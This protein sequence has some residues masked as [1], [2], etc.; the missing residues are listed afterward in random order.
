MGFFGFPWRIAFY[1]IYT[2]RCQRQ[3]LRHLKK[4]QLIGSHFAYTDWLVEE[5]M[6][7]WG[8]QFS[9]LIK[10][11][12]WH[13]TMLHCLKTWDGNTLPG[14]ILDCVIWNK[15]VFKSNFYNGLPA[16]LF[17]IWH[18][19]LRPVYQAVE[20]ASFK[21]SSIVHYNMSL[22]CSNLLHDS[23]SEILQ[24]RRI[25][26]LNLLIGDSFASQNLRLLFRH[27]L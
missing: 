3:Y 19:W 1:L 17:I 9:F 21:F 26:F 20:S 24:D 11:Q 18:S 13:D 16:G 10:F 25:S 6:S 8:F 15:T 7:L 22:L 12:L 4:W 23:L 27:S 5:N 2:I 14:T